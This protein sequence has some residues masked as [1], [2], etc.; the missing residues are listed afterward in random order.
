MGGVVI[1]VS[2]SYSVRYILLR[3]V[4]YLRLFILLHAKIPKKMITRK[5]IGKK[6]INGGYN[7]Q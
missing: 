6:V 5:E 3:F 4:S 7:S 1:L 2:P